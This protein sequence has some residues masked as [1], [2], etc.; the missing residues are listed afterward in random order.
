MSAR[1]AFLALAR[2][3]LL[4][5]RMNPPTTLDRILKKLWAIPRGLSKHDSRV[6]DFLFGPSLPRPLTLGRALAA[7]AGLCF[8]Y[9]G[10]QEAQLRLRCGGQVE[11]EAGSLAEN[12]DTDPMWVKLHGSVPPVDVGIESSDSGNSKAAWIP[13]VSPDDP[14]KAVAIIS[15]ADMGDAWFLQSQKGTVTVEGLA[16]LPR[17]GEG[18]NAAGYLSRLKLRAA[19]GLRVVE[20][21]R[22]PSSLA[23]SVLLLAA[24]VFIAVKALRNVK[25][26]RSAADSWLEPATVHTLASYESE[27]L[28]EEIKVEVRHMLDEVWAE[29]PS[30]SR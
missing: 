19:P 26:I 14:G 1:K 24:G 18:G 2:S 3:L 8:A 30:S 27:P 28:P 21:G 11:V 29:S 7:V 9:V 16:F 17:R 10:F 22:T 23:G 12:R 6:V 5:P 13:L 4:A 15:A 25:L 20:L